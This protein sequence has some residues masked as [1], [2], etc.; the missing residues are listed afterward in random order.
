MNQNYNF[1][2]EWFEMVELVSQE[3]LSVTVHIGQG[4][5]P[6]PL[7]AIIGSI[8]HPLEGLLNSAM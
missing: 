1:S 5:R 7:Q 6:Q 8:S 3:L 2:I 4:L